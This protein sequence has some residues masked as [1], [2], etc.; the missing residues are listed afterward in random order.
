MWATPGVALEPNPD[1]IS[2]TIELIEFAALH[3]NEWR[4]SNGRIIVILRRWGGGFKV[5]SKTQNE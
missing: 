2:G 1:E 5:L 4:W 3:A